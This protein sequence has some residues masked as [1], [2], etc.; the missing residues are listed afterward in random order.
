MTSTASADER[1]KSVSSI[2]KI[3]SPCLERAYAQG[4]KALRKLPK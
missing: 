1:S 3:K 2:L 4:Y